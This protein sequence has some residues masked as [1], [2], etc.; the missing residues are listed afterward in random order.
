MARPRTPKAKASVTGQADKK[1]TRYDARNEPK[2]TDPIGDPPEWIVDT[3]TSKAASAW[4][5]FAREIPWLNSSHRIFVAMACKYQGRIMAGEDIGIQ[6]MNG[7]RQ[8]LGQMGATPADSSKVAIPD[9]EKDDDD[10]LGD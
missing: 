2:I 3:D 5:L 1:R 6:A 9:G 8:M 4:R 10:G 7:L